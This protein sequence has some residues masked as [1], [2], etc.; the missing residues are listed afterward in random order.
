MQCSF[1]MVMVAACLVFALSA[2]GAS[3]QPQPGFDE[4]TPN[5]LPKCPPSVESR[6]PKCAIAMLV[7][8]DEKWVACYCDGNVDPATAPTFSGPVVKR[9]SVVSVEKLV[10]PGG[11]PDPCQLLSIDGKKKYVCW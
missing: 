7:T 11:G 2:A 10:P 3:G 8:T 4:L 5:D 1:R 6:F 9:R